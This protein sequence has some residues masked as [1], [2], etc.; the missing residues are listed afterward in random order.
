M[1]FAVDGERTQ[2]V[3]ILAVIGMESKELCCRGIS[4]QELDVVV[5][6]LHEASQQ[7]LLLLL[8]Y[9]LPGALVFV[10]KKLSLFGKEI[11][12]DALF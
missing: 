2:L 5:A 7:A 3:I 8:L 6:L 12:L 11:R 1:T 4:Q 10:L 9:F